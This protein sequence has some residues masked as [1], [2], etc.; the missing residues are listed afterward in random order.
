MNLY[1]GPLCKM[2]FVSVLALQI[3]IENLFIFFKFHI[4]ISSFVVY[5]HVGSVPLN[6]SE[7]VGNRKRKER[8]GLD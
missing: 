3:H 5:L 2:Y 8:L 7:L 1:S 6:P 4:K